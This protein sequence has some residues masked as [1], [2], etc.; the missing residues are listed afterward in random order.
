M[1]DPSIEDVSRK[2]GLGSLKSQGVFIP[3]DVAIN[4]YSIN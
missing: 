1:K 2:L 4:P 3:N